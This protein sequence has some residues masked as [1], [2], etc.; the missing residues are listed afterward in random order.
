METPAVVGSFPEP[1]LHGNAGKRLP[2]RVECAAPATA[3]C[4]TVLSRLAALG[5]P[6]GSGSLGLLSG[7]QTLRVLVG[8]WGQL[9]GDPVAATLERGPTGSGIY[10][11]PGTAGNTLSLLDQTGAVARVLGPAAGLVAATRQG[12]HQ[13]VWIISGSDQAGLAAAAAALDATALRD[14][15]ALALDHGTAIGLP[16]AGAHANGQT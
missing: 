2:V 8:L 16:V 12:D 6:A 11:R 3:P 15:F 7:S 1:F 9:R 5:V 4:Q 10:A 14:H 13:P